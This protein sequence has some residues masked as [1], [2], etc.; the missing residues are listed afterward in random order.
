V[1]K[2]LLKKIVKKTLKL[3][4]IKK[5]QCNIFISGRTVKMCRT[6]MSHSHRNSQ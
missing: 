3:K 1:L 6:A 2:K 4:M 5:S